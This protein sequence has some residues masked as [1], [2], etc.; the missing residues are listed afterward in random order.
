ME[1]PIREIVGDDPVEFV[2][3]FAR[4]YTQGGYVPAGSGN[5]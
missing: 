5:G 1:R 3:A 2:E 4:N